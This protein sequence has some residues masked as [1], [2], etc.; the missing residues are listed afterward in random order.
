MDINTCPYYKQCLSL[1]DVTVDIMYQT[2]MAYSL[3]N[4]IS[5]TLWCKATAGQGNVWLEQCEKTSCSRTSSQC[6]PGWGP[7]GI[8]SLAM[9]LSNSIQCIDLEYTA[10]I[11]AVVKTNHGCILL[12]TSTVGR[13]K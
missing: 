8:H 11:E 7:I 12:C 2:D 13:I 9:H 4:V 10:F 1:R 6:L 5:D 3:T